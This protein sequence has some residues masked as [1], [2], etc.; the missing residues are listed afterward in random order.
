MHLTRPRSHCRWS[1][2]TRRTADGR[3]LRTAVWICEYPYPT[4]MAAP[5]DC[6]RSA[7]PGG[8]TLTQRPLATD[9][10]LVTS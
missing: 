2:I 4:M 6:E 10:V 9:A 1:T 7:T 3:E 8:L 5:C